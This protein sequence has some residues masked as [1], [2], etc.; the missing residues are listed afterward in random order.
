M[1]GAA[2]S[3]SSRSS[4]ENEIREVLTSIPIGRLRATGLL[5]ALLE[6]VNNASENGSPT[7]DSAASIDD[8]DAAALIRLTEETA[9]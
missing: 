8:M 5:D 2:P 4:E 7:E 3:S 9:V 6:L 1:P